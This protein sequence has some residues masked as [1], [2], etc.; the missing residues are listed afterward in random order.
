MALS[1]A[2]NR[3]VK[4][5]EREPLNNSYLSLSLIH[6]GT[7]VYTHTQTH[8]YHISWYSP[9]S[10]TLSMMIPFC[11]FFTTYKKKQD[12]IQLQVYMVNMKNDY[13]LSAIYY[14]SW[15]LDN[16]KNISKL[17]RLPQKNLLQIITSYITYINKSSNMFMQVHK[18]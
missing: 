16:V 17:H 5:F 8:T 15:R 18:S 7:H 6:I 13:F 3:I 2:S 10:L 9:V 12:S 11:D 14:F 1:R 4:S